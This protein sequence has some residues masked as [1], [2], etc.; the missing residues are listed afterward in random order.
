MQEA[1]E[2]CSIS[3]DFFRLA[4]SMI[5]S[6]AIE[7]PRA[8]RLWLMPARSQILRPPGIDIAILHY[9]ACGVHWRKRTRFVSANVVVS[10]FH[11]QCHGTE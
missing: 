8:S 4:R 5:T 11:S 1:S 9:C 7:S 6:V 2:F 3:A 10:H